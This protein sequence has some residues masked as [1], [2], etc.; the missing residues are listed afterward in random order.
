MLNRI[1]HFFFFGNYFYGFCVVAL[2]LESSF[3]QGLFPH[4]IYYYLILFCATVVYYT[5]A[6]QYQTISSVINDRVLWYIEHKRQINMSQFLL[7]FVLILSSI[8]YVKQN[9]IG[10]FNVSCYSLFSLFLFPLVAI[11]YYGS[12]GQ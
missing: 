5:Y 2:S 1:F 10:S 7:L 9:D 3:Q 12:P 8:L 11:F 6:Y 4:S